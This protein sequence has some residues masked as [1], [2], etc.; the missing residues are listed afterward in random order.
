MDVDR[1]WRLSPSL[2]QKSVQDIAEASA[3]SCLDA[4]ALV[5]NLQLTVLLKQPLGLLIALEHLTGGAQGQH[6]NSHVRQR[7]FQHLDSCLLVLQAKPQPRSLDQV[8][9]QLGQQMLVHFAIGALLQTPVRS[10]AD[11]EVFIT[12]HFMDQQI[13]K[14]FRVQIFS[15][16]LRALVLL[17][18][19]QLVNAA[20]LMILGENVTGQMNGQLQPLGP[21]VGKAVAGDH[22]IARMTGA[23]E[24]RKST[25]LNPVT[26]PSRMP[27]SA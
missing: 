9:G 11:A 18:T 13:M 6:A 22:I 14:P 19:H 26:W 23:E 10:D 3:S 1:L 7:A 27:S 16:D 25:R 17:A 21:P 20:G 8:G 2:L 5:A 15:I 12:V 24:D 4:Q